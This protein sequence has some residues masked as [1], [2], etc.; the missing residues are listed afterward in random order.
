MLHPVGTADRWLQRA[1]EARAVAEQLTDPTAKRSML[2]IAENYE[3]LAKAAEARE[4]GI[5]VPPS[6]KLTRDG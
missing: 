2:A 5:Y 1:A 6:E 3:K 4:A